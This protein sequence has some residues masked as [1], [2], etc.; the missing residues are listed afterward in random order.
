MVR[1]QFYLDSITQREPL[2][3]KT[4][5]ESGIGVIVVVVARRPSK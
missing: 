1:A 3:K 4:E 5:N 2:H